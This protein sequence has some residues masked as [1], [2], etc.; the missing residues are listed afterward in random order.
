M[1]YRVLLVAP[2][3]DLLSVDAEIEDVM[4]SGLIVDPLLG[5]VTNTALLRRIRE[6]EYDALWFATHG[7][8]E[9][10]KLS[11]G[12]LSASALVPL[13]RDRFS[14]VF[15]NTC[16]SLPVA[17]MLQ[18]EANVSVI[19]TLLD[20]PDLQAYQTG[21]NLATALAE[22]SS[23][24]EAYTASKPG[25]NRSYLYLP[26]LGPPHDS[27]S[28]VLVA[29]A[30]LRAEIKKIRDTIQIDRK[31]WWVVAMFSCTVIG[32]LLWWIVWFVV[33]RVWAI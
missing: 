25:Q 31:F 2:R 29:I 15:L 18:E 9:G 23:V 16:N 26:L 7:S 5:N 12:M 27:L 22:S 32:V 6:G 24:A 1:G 28:G 21:S 8:A 11:D 20:V 14:L 33:R 10:I 19:C 3:S 13:V 4:R 30:D 17:Q